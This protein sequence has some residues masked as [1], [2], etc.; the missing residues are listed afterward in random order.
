MA[1]DGRSTEDLFFAL[2]VEDLQ[3]AADLFA[4]I[5]EATGGVD[6]WVSLEVSPLLVDDTRGTIQVAASLHAQAGAQEP[7]HQDPRYA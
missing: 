3:Q 6:G 7:V 2:A 4:P 1:R 5:H